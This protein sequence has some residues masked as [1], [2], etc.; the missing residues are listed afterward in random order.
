MATAESDNRASLKMDVPASFSRDNTKL[1]A[2]PR[3]R[4]EVFSRIDVTLAAVL[5]LWAL[6]GLLPLAAWTGVGERAAYDRDLALRGWGVVVALLLTLLLLAVTRGRCAGWLRAALA[7]ASTVPRGPYLIGLGLL[8][9]AEAI[10]VALLCFARN[11]QL[12]D[13]WAQYVQARTFAAGALAAPP[14]PAPAHFAILQ[15]VVTPAGWFSQYPPL[16]P[17]LLA[18]GMTLGAAWLVTPLLGALLPAAVYWLGRQSGDERVARLAAALTVLSPFVI[19]MS[20]SGMN[21]VPAA[22]CVAAGLAL[23]PAV[24]RGQ[25]GAALGFGV[26]TGLAVGIRPLDALA[27]GVVGGAALCAQLV[28]QLRG[29]GGAG[30]SPA[31]GVGHRQRA[32]HERPAGGP[33]ALPG[34][35]AKALQNTVAMLAGGAIAALPTLLFNAATTGDVLTF[36]YSALYGAGHR[37]GFHEGPWGQA[38]T[39]LRAVGLT[40][41]DAHELDTY[42]FEWPVPVT[43]LIVAAVADRRGLDPARR[44]AAAYLAVLAGL[45]FFYFHRDLLYGPRFL[46]SAVPAVLV[47]TAAGIA[48]LA[49]IERP[50]PRLGIRGG[51]AVVVFV[52][53]LALQSAIWLAP[54]RLASYSAGGTVLALHPEDDA[55]RAGLQHAVVV[56]RD[57]LGT[58]LI[59]RLWEAGV[60]VVLSGRLYDAFDACALAELLERA[61]ADGMR[62]QAL[63][64]RLQVAARTASPGRYAP[65]TTR[66]PFLRLPDSGQ[67][68]PACA[69]EIEWDRAGTM[70]YAAVAHLNEPGFAGDLIWARELP[71]LSALRRLYPDRPI[72]RYAQPAPGAAAMFT[73]VD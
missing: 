57:G 53:V 18:L 37:L 47:L 9:A 60:P 27:L 10:A 71:D 67:L 4:G 14:P 65:G 13:T 31:D 44:S 11:P 48:R 34:A 46:F 2:S 40:A 41:T 36:G 63:I 19:A 28:W 15:M 54:L 38:L 64:E 59:V 43:L 25:G 58:R 17:A 52:A 23:L 24:S 8:A 66:D 50:L 70:Q 5:T 35:V 30:G 68:T 22:L 3:L 42:V 62:G 39:P 33:P 45:L 69:A 72:Y 16:H 49:A 21:H 29:A 20:A 73:P 55:Q 12:V 61:E 1:S 56:V 32:G 7:R 51:D 26:L 6:A